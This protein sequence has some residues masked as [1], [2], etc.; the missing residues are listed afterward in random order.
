MRVTFRPI[1]ARDAEFLRI[2]KP[3]PRRAGFRP[4]GNVITL[5]GRIAVAFDQSGEVIYQDGTETVADLIR[6]YKNVVRAME[7]LD[8]NEHLRLRGNS[9]TLED[10]LRD[11]R[12]A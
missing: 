8:Y 2:R 1:D 3:P 6:A 4:V 5:D 11:L 7:K 9:R 12:D 10:A